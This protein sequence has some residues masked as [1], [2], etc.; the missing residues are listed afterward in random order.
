MAEY[1]GMMGISGM[2]ITL[3][4]GGWQAP[5]PML[6]FVPSWVWFFSKLFALIW[7][8]IWVRATLPRLRADQLMDLAWK[9]FLPLGLLN[10]VCA[11]I[12][13][14]AASIGA[15]ARGSRFSFPRYSDCGRTCCAEPARPV[16]AAFTNSQIDLPWNHPFSSSRG[17]SP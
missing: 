2:A 15:G 16:V 3:F 8:F 7:I 9:F 5:L 13:A 6:G 12:S 4:L 11:G 1:F 17:S 10:L 14:K